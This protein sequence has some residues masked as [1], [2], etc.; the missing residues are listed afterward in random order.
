ML[1]LGF[2][3]T[4]DIINKLWCT[5]KHLRDRSN[6][7]ILTIKFQSR[8]PNTNSQIATKTLAW[9]EQPGTSNAATQELMCEV[10]TAQYSHSKLF[11][12]T[13]S[14]IWY[15]ELFCDIVNEE[16]NSTCPLLFFIVNTSR[17]ET[18]NIQSKKESKWQK[19]FVF[20]TLHQPQ[21]KLGASQGGRLTC[22]GHDLW[23]VRVT[24]S[25]LLAYSDKTIQCRTEPRGGSAITV[26]QTWRH[27]CLVG[28]FPVTM[29]TDK[30]QPASSVIFFGQTMC[31]R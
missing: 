31:L 10:K 23:P 12:E 8:K 19:V 27:S 11:H 15:T 18:L 22:Q 29:V 13:N 5:V 25:D 30:L 9:H 14:Q 16:Q 26:T 1:N 3:A 2:L 28:T 17:K 6:R 20:D 24:T 4:T 7:A 21:R